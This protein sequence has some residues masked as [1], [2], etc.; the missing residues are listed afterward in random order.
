[1]WK[2]MQIEQ[3]GACREQ[4]VRG[5][6]TGESGEEAG[7]QEVNMRETDGENES[8]EMMELAVKTRTAEKRQHKGKNMVR[9]KVGRQTRQVTKTERTDSERA[10]KLRPPLMIRTGLIKVKL[11][12]FFSDKEQFCASAR[13]HIKSGEIVSPEKYRLQKK[14]S[15]V[16]KTL[17]K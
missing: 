14:L 4:V 15:E 3:G 7:T 12:H 11:E 10:A 17:W 1:M 5:E 8:V 6:E 2:N 13:L 9:A 16:G